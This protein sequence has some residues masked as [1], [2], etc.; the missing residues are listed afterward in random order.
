[1]LFQIRWW[2]PILVFLIIRK[3]MK[4]WIIRNLCSSPMHFLAY[5]ID[6]LLYWDLLVYIVHLFGRI[7][8]HTDECFYWCH[9]LGLSSSNWTVASRS[10]FYTGTIWHTCRLYV[11]LALGHCDYIWLSAVQLFGHGAFGIASD[12]LVGF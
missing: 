1:M 2:K 3:S 4:V 5:F 9:S 8:I 7:N 10:S 11:C 12:Y 6:C